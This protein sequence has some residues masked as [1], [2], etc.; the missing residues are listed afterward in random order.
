MMNELDNLLYDF[1]N[2]FDRDIPNYNRD[3][4]SIPIQYKDIEK[5]NKI[6]NNILSN[7]YNKDNIIDYAI[8]KYRNQP[9]ERIFI[10]NKLFLMKKYIELSIILNKMERF[11]GTDKLY[12]EIENTAYYTYFF[13]IVG[14]IGVRDL[15]ETYNFLKVM[16]IPIEDDF[17]YLFDFYKNEHELFGAEKFSNFL[18]NKIDKRHIFKIFNKIE[19]QTLPKNYNKFT[20]DFRFFLIGKNSKFGTFLL[21]NLDKWN[22]F[23]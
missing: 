20:N 18:K 14:E 19:I 17:Q 16:E 6:F 9:I 22:I 3:Y 8:E 1:F 23:V 2:T 11:T 5:Y 15:F 7:N 4:I 13:S 21:K 12:N 10:K